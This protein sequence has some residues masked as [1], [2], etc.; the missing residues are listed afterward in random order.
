MEVRTLLPQLCRTLPN[1][2]LSLSFHPDYWLE[3]SIIWRLERG[4]KSGRQN[5]WRTLKRYRPCF[6]DSIKKSAHKLLGV[7][8]HRSTSTGPWKHSVPHASPTHTPT[9]WSAPCMCFWQWNEWVVANWHL[10]TC[11]KLAESA[12]QG[13]TT[14]LNFR[15]TCGKTKGCEHRAWCVIGSK[16]VE[17]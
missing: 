16:G 10:S 13:E 11:R 3:S 7:L 2:L 4:Y 14:N 9:L 1:R 8:H 15:A 6:A 17:A 5:S 12:G